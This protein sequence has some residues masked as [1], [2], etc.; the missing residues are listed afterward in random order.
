MTNVV[1]NIKDIIETDNKIK[2]N[3]PTPKRDAILDFLICK[4]IARKTTE[5]IK[6][7]VVLKG[8]RITP[9]ELF[10]IASENIGKEDLC[11]YILKNYPSIDSKEK[12]I[13]GLLYNIKKTNTLR[14]IIGIM[15][16]LK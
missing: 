16:N 7:K 8:T 6:G 4:A 2:I 9:Q 10:Y 5:E 3:Y 11:T 14:Y 1:T 15:I 12:I 13:Y